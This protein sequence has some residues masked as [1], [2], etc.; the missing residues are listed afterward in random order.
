MN[1]LI[2]AER[3]LRLAAEETAN[4]LRDI[5]IEIARGWCADALDPLLKTDGAALHSWTV[6]QWRDFLIDNLSVPDRSL[7]DIENLRSQLARAKRELEN[8]QGRV[9]VLERERDLLKEAVASLQAERIPA[10]SQPAP[11]RSAAAA[12]PSAPDLPA[13]SP[14]VQFDP[15]EAARYVP[16]RFL[17]EDLLTRGWELIGKLIPSQPTRAEERQLLQRTLHVIQVL[18]HKGIVARPELMA[19]LHLLWTF[20]KEGAK[21]YSSIQR[22]LDACLKTGLITVLLDDNSYGRGKPVR[23]FA[24][25]DLGQ[26]VYTAL[27]RQPPNDALWRSKQRHGDEQALKHTV[28]V[29]RAAAL[30]ELFQ[31]A[32]V[33]ANPAPI[34]VPGGHSFQPDLI[35]WPSSG[36]PGSRRPAHFLECE[37]TKKSLAEREQ[38]WLNAYYAG[39]GRIWVVCSTPSVR[40]HVIEQIEALLGDKGNLQLFST[41]VATLGT[42]L[43]KDNEKKDGAAP[44]LSGRRFW[45]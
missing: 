6:R 41:D 7:Q 17:D 36:L 21:G 3:R 4:G 35:A 23:V 38:K 37:R 26:E 16:T 1:N 32:V 42:T 24:L 33:D 22:R 20:D 14:S 13:S 31:D 43:M 8:A 2:E 28:L 10:P 27:W 34:Q 11:P 39:Q 15:D 19:W 40:S 29:S 5:L 12:A 45:L 30:L 9:Q 44:F 25:S 18:G